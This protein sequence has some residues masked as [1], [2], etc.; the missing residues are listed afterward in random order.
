MEN[1]PKELTEEQ[2]ASIAEEVSSVLS[3]NIPV[4]FIKDIINDSYLY[5]DGYE[6]AKELEEK[7]FNVNSNLVRKLD[8]V[9]YY[10][11][12][13]KRANE[14]KWVKD[15]NI[16]PKYRENDKVEY[17]IKYHSEEL[18]LRNINGIDY[19]GGYYKVEIHKGNSQCSALV[20]FEDL[21]NNIKN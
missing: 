15:N 2:V 14:K 17:S 20:K 1:R 16:K 18:R 12:E 7:G 10:I 13:Q 4:A 9:E 6:I 3:A 19:E 11:D 8:N 21:E 5:L